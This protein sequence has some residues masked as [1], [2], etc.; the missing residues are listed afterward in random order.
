[1]FLPTCYFVTRIVNL[2]AAA[3]PT[4]PASASQTQHLNS[5]EKDEKV[6]LIG[7]AR[8]QHGQNEDQDWAVVQHPEAET[9]RT[10][11]TWTFQA[12]SISHLVGGD[13][14]SRYSAGI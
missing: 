6:H 1:M 13:I 11:L 14:S 7:E 3:I 2:I 9:G 12:I 10:H 8:S 4:V 5:D